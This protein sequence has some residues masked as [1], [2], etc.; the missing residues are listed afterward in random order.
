MKRA[1][2]LSLAQVAAFGPWIGIVQA[3]TEITHIP[4]VFRPLALYE[5]QYRLR[6]GQRVALA[7][8]EETLDFIRDARIR[9]VTIAGPQGKGIVVGP[10]TER[11]G[12]ELAASLLAEPGEY[13]VTLSARSGTGEE[14]ATTLAVILDPVQTVPVNS[15]NPPVVALDGW[16]FTCPGSLSGTFGSMAD[17]LH[18]NGSYQVPVVYFFDNCVE[19]PAPDCTIEEL[20]NVLGQVLGLIKYDNGVLVSQVD[21][22]AHSMGGLIVR[23]YLSGKQDTSGVFAPLSNPRVRKTIFIAT[24]HFG[25]YQADSS[26]ASLDV[27]AANQLNEMNPGSPFLCVGSA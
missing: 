20:G 8:P 19:C 25:S 23:S 6:A 7:A 2:L 10:N 27:F 14:R 3:Q 4:P 15:P 5:S 22:I 26:L 13:V 17:L 1:A 18:D 21:L 24:P 16:Q 11:N 12:I 9:T